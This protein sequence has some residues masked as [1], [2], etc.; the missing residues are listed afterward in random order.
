M[1]LMCD[2]RRLSRQAVDETTRIGRIVLRD[3]V[4]DLLQPEKRFVGPVRSHSG[5]SDS[6]KRRRT[7]LFSVTRPASLSA[8]PSSMS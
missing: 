7:S 5:S 8:S 3:V 4:V 2:Q 1:R 6:P